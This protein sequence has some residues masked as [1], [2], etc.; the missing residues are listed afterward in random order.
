MTTTSKLQIPVE[1]KDGRSAYAASLQMILKHVADF[2][3]TVVDII[4]EKYNIPVDEIMNTVTSDSR[5]TNMLVNPDIHTLSLNSGQEEQE[6]KQEQKQEQEQAQDSDDVIDVQNEDEQSNHD[7]NADNADNADNTDN[8]DNTCCIRNELARIVNHTMQFDFVM[9][10][11]PTPETAMSET[12]Q[13]MYVIKYDG[14]PRESDGSYFF[15]K[16]IHT[17]QSSHDRDCIEL[18]WLRIWAELI[19]SR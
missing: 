7:D 6:Q 8:T 15:W 16:K 3:I 2:H 4:S 13:C 1:I 19:Q 14:F 17:K 10:Q 9:C 5:Y 11:V 18:Q 12:P